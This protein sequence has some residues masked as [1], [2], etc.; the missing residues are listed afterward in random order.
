MQNVVDTIELTPSKDDVFLFDEEGHPPKT[1]TLEEHQV[2]VV[3]SNIILHL[4]S[5]L[6]SQ[7]H[8]HKI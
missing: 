1:L 5:F 7:W 4:G 2:F 8:I 3:S 6:F